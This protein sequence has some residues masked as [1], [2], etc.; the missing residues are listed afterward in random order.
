MIDSTV[1]AIPEEAMNLL[2]RADDLIMDS[3]EK[4]YELTG[5]IIELHEEQDK[6]SVYQ[7]GLGLVSS[8]PAAT[9]LRLQVVD[10]T[11]TAHSLRNDAD[12]VILEGEA[13][14]N[15]V[16]IEGSAY[17]RL[18]LD[19]LMKNNS[20]TWV[21][22]TTLDPDILEEPH[23]PFDLTAMEEPFNISLRKAVNLM[24]FA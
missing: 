6:L 22:A 15:F 8:Y 4:D 17:M 10:G 3:L 5:K 9:M 16:V 7:L 19:G 24:D 11:L 12:E 14:E 23:S 18:I 2:Y 13:L 1:P 20:S 21:Y